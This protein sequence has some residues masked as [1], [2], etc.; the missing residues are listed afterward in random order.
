M[1]KSEFAKRLA[2]ILE[3]WG[4][5][6]DLDELMQILPPGNGEIVEVIE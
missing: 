3:R 4:Y 2:K 6:V 1:K 5:K